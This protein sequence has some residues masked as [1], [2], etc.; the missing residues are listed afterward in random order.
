MPVD[1]DWKITLSTPM[2]PQDADLSVTADGET[3]TGTIAGGVIEPRAISGQVSGD[4]LSFSFDVA[5]P[6]PLTID[7]RLTVAGDTIEGSAKLGM[8]GDAK[9]TGRRA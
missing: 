8:F 3:F 6:M 9:V 4:T 1:G 5:Q 2:G 7:A